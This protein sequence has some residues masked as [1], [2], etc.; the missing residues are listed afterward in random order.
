MKAGEKDRGVLGS[1]S[2]DSM[3][4]ICFPREKVA[5][6]EKFTQRQPQTESRKGIRMSLATPNAIHVP[7][8]LLLKILIFC[9]KAGLDFELDEG[10]G[11]HFTQGCV[12]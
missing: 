4:C 5:A 7:A 10:S 1:L 11:L 9:G 12:K 2:I 8:S 3:G 6:I